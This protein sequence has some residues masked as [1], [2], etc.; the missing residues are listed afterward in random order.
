LRAAEAQA[1]AA[2]KEFSRRLISAQEQE[3]K[4]LAN[5]LHDS[6]GQNLSLIKNRAYLALNR[7]E[8]APETAAHLQA[9]DEVASAAIDEVRNLARNLRP[10]HIDQFGLTDAISNLLDRVAQSSDLRV[11]RRLQNVDLF[12]GEDATHVY[13]MVQETLNNVIKHAR[14]TRLLVALER[15]LRCV[16][17]RVEDDGCGFELKALGREPNRTGIG[18]NSLNERV[19]MLGGSLTIQ[20]APGQGTRIQIE[21][22][23]VDPPAEA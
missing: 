12:R 1:L 11:E 5:E 18:L 23:A 14:A 17:I 16:R 2:S 21:L 22:P 9:I 8:L 6:L 3:R 19:R 4:R 20:T 13:R 15:D 10:L 7:A